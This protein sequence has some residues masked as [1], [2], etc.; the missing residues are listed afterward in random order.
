MIRPIN[1]KKN[2]KKADFSC[3]IHR[4]EVKN[5]NLKTKTRRV[6]SDDGGV[7]TQDSQDSNII[8][9]SVLT[10]PCACITSF[11]TSDEKNKLVFELGQAKSKDD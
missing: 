3:D 1:I 10:L 2:E 7:V 6:K 5:L 8:D 11:P 4:G 9:G